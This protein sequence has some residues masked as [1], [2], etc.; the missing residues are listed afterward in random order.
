MTVGTNQP[1]PRLARAIAALLV[2]LAA[3]GCSGTIPPGVADA[4]HVEVEYHELAADRPN[5]DVLLVSENDPKYAD[6]ANTVRRADEINVKRAPDEAIEHLVDF[7]ASHDFFD[8]AQRVD[9]PEE[10]GG[11]DARAMIV[12]RGDGEPHAMVLRLGMER[13]QIQ[14]FS[15]VS[16]E[17]A[18]VFAAIPTAQLVDVG[19]DAGEF[20]SEQQRKLEANAQQRGRSGR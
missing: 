16:F 6:V 11:A 10:V 9:G 14:T 4:A 15:D 7:A 12:F 2:A 5:T 20:F 3:S 8:Y 18:K 17:I 13:D 19:G 1:V